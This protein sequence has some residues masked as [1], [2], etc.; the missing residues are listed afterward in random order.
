MNKLNSISVIVLMVII[1]H[2]VK[3]QVIASEDFNYMAGSTIGGAN[4][5]TGWAGSWTIIT[6]NNKTISADSI[7][8]FRTG[9]ATGTALNVDFPPT[10]GS[11]R[12]ERELATPI[13]DNGNT[14]WFGFDAVYSGIGGNNANVVGLV[15]TATTAATG[16]NGQLVLIGKQPASVGTGF[17]GLG[18]APSTTVVNQKK[19]IQDTYWMVVKIKFS[20][21][22][23]AD[24]VYLFLNPDPA[25]E[26]TNK[27]ADVVYTIP[28]GLN[29]G[30][31]GVYVKVEGTPTGLNAKYDNMILGN[32]YADI[33]AT[34]INPLPKYRQVREKFNYT[35]GTNLIG[36]GTAVDGWNGAWTSVISPNAHPMVASRVEN[37]VLLKQTTPNALSMTLVNETRLKRD[38]AAVYRDNGLTYWL[39]FF[40][41]YTNA[42]NGNAMNVMLVNNGVET[43]AASG[44]PGQLLAIGKVSAN[45][46]LGL[47][48]PPT[49]FAPGIAGIANRG[50]WFVAKIETNGTSA[51]DTVRLYL[52]P[53]TA[54]EPAPGSEV[55]KY[56][57]DKLNNG[58][59]AIGLKVTGTPTNLQALVDDLYL[60]LSFDEIV[61]EDLG[62]LDNAPDPAFEKF[63]YATNTPINTTTTL[64]S[65]SGGW[66]G[67]WKS[68][69]AGASVQDDSV[70][71]FH[72][73][74]S[75]AGNALVIDRNTTDEVRLFRG[76]KTAYRDNTRTYWMG[77]WYRTNTFTSGELFQLSLGD[78]A[79]FSAS[80][81]AGQF[82][83]VGTMADNKNLKLFAN[84]QTIV[85]V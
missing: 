46:Q 84:P 72:N 55:M 82:L 61:P 27:M 6:G 33:I 78:T 54:T 36:S 11:A 62:V 34:A 4:G 13:T 31:N 28:T 63:E 49:F 52:N 37:E 81:E 77:F 17:L 45:D 80:G 50:N 3:A 85:L 8:N 57:A 60:G 15:N 26:P 19:K 16:P 20:G 71:N 58:W 14:Y 1:G 64:G 73:L 48:R 35:A 69:S 25:V 56:A 51:V 24:T 53:N 70:R 74:R 39:G 67:S 65:K 47:G 9:K 5:G 40:A 12:M 30:F 22:A 66:N 75:T 23:S 76:L 68:L 18:T 7:K 21:N 59:R 41:K 38:L 79:T 43:M 42:A 32:N 44:A 2:S 10:S 83:R 29:N